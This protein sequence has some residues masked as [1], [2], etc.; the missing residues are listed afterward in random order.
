MKNIIFDQGK[1]LVENNFYVIYKELGYEAEK[2]ALME[3]TASVLEFESGRI[4]RQEF[5]F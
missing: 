3:S 5:Y 4:T 1:V 2:E